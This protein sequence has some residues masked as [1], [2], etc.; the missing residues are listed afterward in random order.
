MWYESMFDEVEQYKDDIQGKKMASYIDK[1]IGW[2]LRDYSRTNPTWVRNFIDN[3]K[4]RLSKLSMKE[5]SKY[6]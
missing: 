4:D 2:S 1:A 5:A 3:H 6:L